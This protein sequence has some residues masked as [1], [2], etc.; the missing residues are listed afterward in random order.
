M[1]KSRNVKVFCS[2]LHRI[3]FDGIS[4]ESY[5]FSPFFS[6]FPYCVSPP[7]ELIEK[8]DLYIHGLLSPNIVK[9]LS[10][11]ISPQANEAVNIVQ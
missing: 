5:V 7:S 8:A 2:S 3:Q 11:I 1:C 10:F 4:C 6:S 9:K